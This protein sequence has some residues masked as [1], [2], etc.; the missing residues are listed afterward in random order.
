MENTVKN[1]LNQEYKLEESYYDPT[2]DY[3]DML[4]HEYDDYEDMLE[5]EELIIIED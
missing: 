3:E 1:L 5:H 2:E 4:E